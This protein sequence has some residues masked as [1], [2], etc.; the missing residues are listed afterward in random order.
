MTQIRL[1][2]TVWTAQTTWNLMF[3]FLI[4]A[5][6]YMWSFIRC[7]SDFFAKPPQSK[8]HLNECNFYVTRNRNWEWRKNFQSW[9]EEVSGG[10][11]KNI[12]NSSAVVKHSSGHSETLEQQSAPF[13]APTLLTQTL[14]YGSCNQ[15]PTKIHCF[16]LLTN[17]L[18]SAAHQLINR[19]VNAN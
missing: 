18:A 11:V 14:P 5:T 19:T 1:F 15:A 4:W 6:F 3:S 13:Q 8:Q 17:S 10:T 16:H 7:R 12:L 9:K 2:I